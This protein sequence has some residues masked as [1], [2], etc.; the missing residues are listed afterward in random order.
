MRRLPILLLVSLLV[1]GCELAGDIFKGGL[2]T[3]VI[4]VV[5]VV[6]VIGWI[7]GRFRK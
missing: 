3:G 1:T 6:L 5:V 2:I 4:L 7:F